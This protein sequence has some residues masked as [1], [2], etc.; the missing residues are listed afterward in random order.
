MHANLPKDGIL[1]PAQIAE[2]TYV[3]ITENSVEIHFTDNSYLR[4]QPRDFLGGLLR[5]TV[6][7]NREEVKRI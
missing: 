4:A 2:I 7:E 1:T 6:N 5:L 3:G